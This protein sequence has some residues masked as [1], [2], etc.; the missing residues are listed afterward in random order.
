MTRLQGPTYP[1]LF[2]QV[3][4]LEFGGGPGQAD[5]QTLSVFA[6]LHAVSRN[7]ELILNWFSNNGQQKIQTTS[8]QLTQLLT[9]GQFQVTLPSLEKAAPSL[10]CTYNL[11]DTAQREQRMSSDSLAEFVSK[12]YL[13]R[14]QEHNP[15]EFDEQIDVFLSSHKVVDD[16]NKNAMVATPIEPA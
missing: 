10:S 11:T 9:S 13:S 16:A 8:L 1:C 7:M 15:A 12:L 4:D 5:G 14:H 6:C 2:A 3:R